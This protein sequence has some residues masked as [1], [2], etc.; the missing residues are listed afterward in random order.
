MKNIKPESSK[1]HKETLMIT[2]LFLNFFE[3]MPRFTDRLAMYNLA[4]FVGETTTTTLC[5]PVEVTSKTTLVYYEI[6]PFSVH[7]R[8]IMLYI[9]GLGLKK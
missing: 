9:T 2:H 8:P 3:C 1:G 5:R 6:C 4:K 7:F